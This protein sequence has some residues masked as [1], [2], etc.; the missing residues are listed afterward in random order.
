MIWHV[1]MVFSITLIVGSI[2]FNQFPSLLITPPFNSKTFDIS[3]TNYDMIHHT[4]LALFFTDFRL[5]SNS[6]AENRQCWKKYCLRKQNSTDT[7]LFNSNPPTNPPQTFPHPPQTLRFT[8]HTH[9]PPPPFPH[10]FGSNP[11]KHPTSIQR[12]V[13]PSNTTIGS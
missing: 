1:G 7:K 13:I 12:P 10:H 11:T 4:S 2:I 8:P 9:S 6:Q 3:L 5:I